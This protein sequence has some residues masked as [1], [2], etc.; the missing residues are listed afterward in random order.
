MSRSGIFGLQKEHLRGGQIGDVIVNRR[1]DKNDVLFE[2]PGINVVS[3]LA[4]A[5]LFDHHGYES[6][7]AIFWF[8]VEIFHLSK[9]LR[10]QE[11]EPCHFDS[12][13]GDGANSGI[14][15]EPVES[16]VT[17]QLRF[18][19]IERTLLCQTSVNCCCG[20]A[21]MSW[22]RVPARDSALRR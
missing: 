16:F 9:V 17:P 20:F 3:A 19:P 12:V 6:R 15:R 18:H 4:A 22:R 10:V 14:L 1:A 13:C 7:P 21:T 2:Q 5:G 11:P 8:V